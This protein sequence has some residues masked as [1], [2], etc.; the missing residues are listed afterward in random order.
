MYKSLVGS[1][2]YWTITRPDIMY[3]VG[4]VS[5]YMNESR[6]KHFQAAKRILTYVKGSIDQGLFYTQCEDPRLVGYTN[7]DYGGDLDERKSMSG[8]VFNIGS[9]AFTWSSKK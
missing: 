6:Q 5:R 1:L 7:S 3:V 8:F 2:R 9:V 4:L